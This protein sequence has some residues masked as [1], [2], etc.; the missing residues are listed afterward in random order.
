M[1]K[2]IIKYS[3]LKVRQRCLLV[4]QYGVIDSNHALASV[5]INKNEKLKSETKL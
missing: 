2:K 3:L 4:G 5:L 1:V